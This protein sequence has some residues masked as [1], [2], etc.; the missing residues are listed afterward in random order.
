MLQIKAEFWLQE[1][2]VMNDEGS[3]DGVKKWL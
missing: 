1:L 3:I 2:H